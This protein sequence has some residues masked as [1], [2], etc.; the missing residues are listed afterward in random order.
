MSWKLALAMAASF[1]IAP[2]AEAQTL[3]RLRLENDTFMRLDRWQTSRLELD[4]VTHLKS[5][6][7]GTHH[8]LRVALGQVMYTPRNIQFVDPPERDHAFGAWLYGDL[9]WLLMRIRKPFQHRA[10]L[11]LRAGVIGP[12][13]GAEP[14]QDATHQALGVRRPHGWDNQMPNQFAYVLR[15]AYAPSICIAIDGLRLHLTL[16]GMLDL[17][18]AHRRF[19]AGGGI[20]LSF[21]LEASFFDETLSAAPA[22]ADRGLAFWVAAY[23]EA[24][25]YD[26]F[27]AATGADVRPAIEEASF[28][29]HLRG[30]WMLLR[31][32]F[33]LSVT[34]TIHRR[35]FNVV[36]RRRLHPPAHSYM[37][38]ELGARL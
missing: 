27:I 20:A 14:V 34:F 36:P 16:G 29:P 21:Q 3:L 5:M 17:G 7:A 18:N 6:A 32:R 1:V 22:A 23:G 15:A 13:A 24:V 30:G 31:K 38:V 25:W 35:T 11:M 10:L 19:R 8:H 4:A 2:A 37:G 12:A 33:W 28:V 9:G 26:R